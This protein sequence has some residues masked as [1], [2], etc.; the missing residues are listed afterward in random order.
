[1]VS[2]Q[3]LAYYQELLKHPAFGAE[4]FDLAGLRE[5]M[6]TRQA[7]ADPDI[8]VT[9]AQVGDLP[10]EWVL[11]PCADPDLRLARAAFRVGD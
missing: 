10:G 2:P 4:G 3:G 7:P 6:A 8:R 1:M 11:A 5:G 9:P